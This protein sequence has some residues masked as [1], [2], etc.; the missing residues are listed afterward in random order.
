[1]PFIAI[2]GSCLFVWIILSLEAKTLNYQIG[3]IS[4]ATVVSF[5]WAMLFSMHAD[6]AMIGGR[7]W[8][9][10]PFFSVA[11]NDA[12]AY[13][14]GKAFGRHQLIGLSPNKTI[15]GF[16]GG[17]IFNIMWTTFLAKKILKESHIWMCGP[18]RFTLPFENYQCQHLPKV[19]NLQVYEIPF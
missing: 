15:E 13:F 12:M 14:A 16:I 6:T 2:L 19:Y 3:R 17:L 18:L 4:H 8:Y 10:Y 7:L 1:M 9:W 11:M 5:T